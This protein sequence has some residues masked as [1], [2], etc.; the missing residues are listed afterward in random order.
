MVLMRP[1]TGGTDGSSRLRVCLASSCLA[2]ALRSYLATMLRS[3]SSDGNLRVSTSV[4]AR[5]PLISKTSW[6][7]R[8]ATAAS[9]ADWPSA[10]SCCRTR[11]HVRLTDQLGTHEWLQST[12]EWLDRRHSDS[13]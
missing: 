6:S 5:T 7:P 3:T 2:R 4:A 13:R 10:Y 1:T 8:K 11:S 12:V 9:V